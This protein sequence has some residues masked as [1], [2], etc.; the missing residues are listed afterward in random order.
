MPKIALIKGDGVGPDILNESIKIIN[1]LNDG[2]NLDLQVVEFEL[3]ADHYL[4]T[5]L[6]IPEELVDELKNRFK[7]IVLGPL[8]DKRVSN[9]IHARQ[10]I[11]TLIRELNLFAISRPVSLLSSDLCPLEGKSE[12]EI[13]FL[14]TYD[15]SGESYPGLGGSYN[16]G[17]ED[18]ISIQEIIQTKVGVENIITFA[19]KEALRYGRKK[20]TMVDN[21]ISLKFGHDL[22]MRIFRQVRHKF[23][24]VS[25]SHIPMNLV[26]PQLV[27][28]PDRFD[29]IVTNH[30]YGSIISE[31]GA[32]FQGGFAMAT[33]LYCDGKG[34]VM[35]RPMIGS[36]Q[37][38][39]G[40][41]YA[42]P[43][44]AILCVKHVM[45]HFQK[46]KASK[47]IITSLKKALKSG[48]VTRDLG[49]SLGTSEV[50]DYI[51]S[52]MMELT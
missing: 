16:R 24:D 37:Q 43:M 18:E 7:V 15:S 26:V 12:S 9:N 38:Y 13:D 11:S 27:T 21:P 1:A 19:F 41:D 50:G 45:D 52:E 17:K 48:W 32:A 51:C 22:W 49:G 35:I 8:G 42:N 20:V 25:A 23:P 33:Q 46:K 14:V 10:I 29:I 44:S 31:L 30:L 39:I 3:S 28:D 4:T 40:K 5:G 47:A 34:L 2:F 6:T 36:Q